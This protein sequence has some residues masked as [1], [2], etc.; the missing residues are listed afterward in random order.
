MTHRPVHN[1]LNWCYRT[2]GFGPE[3]VGLCVT[4]LG[5]DLS[6]FDIFGLLG[7]GGGLYI[8]DDAEQRDP[9]LLL[10]VLLTEP[11][12]FWDSVP[13]TLNQ[14]ASLLSR[15]DEWRELIIFVWCFF[16]VTTRRWLCRMRCAGCSGERRL[17]VSAGRLRRRCG[18]TISVFVRWIRGGGVFRMAV[19]S[20]MRVITC[21]TGIWS[22]VRLV[23][24]VICTSVG[25]VCV[26]VMPAGPG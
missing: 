7:C 21:S 1:L 9:G 19:L 13:T 6:V 10:D 3:D 11:V 5:F 14:V 22:R 15:Q 18:R 8:A 16:P 25:S 23:L 24:R 12:T 2:F 17:S 20:T 4:S 26:P